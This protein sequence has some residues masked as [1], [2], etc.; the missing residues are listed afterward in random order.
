MA[1]GDEEIEKL[2]VV[3]PSS[4]GLKSKY[5]WVDPVLNDENTMGLKLAKTESAVEPVS[6]IG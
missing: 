5:D 1:R 2:C 4:S 6:M 3:N